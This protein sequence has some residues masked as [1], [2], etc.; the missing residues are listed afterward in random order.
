M[1]QR[2]R[3]VV[4]LATAAAIVAAGWWGWAEWA[5]SPE[6]SPTEQVDEVRDAPA[7][8]ARPNTQEANCRA[9]LAAW[10]VGERAEIVRRHGG[11]AQRV[12]DN[13]RWRHGWLSR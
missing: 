4:D 7:R 9:D 6:R 10:D 8:P 11:R 5:D 2:L 3:P 12:I 13:C 1:D